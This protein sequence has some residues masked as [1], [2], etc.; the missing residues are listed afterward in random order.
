MLSH[1]ND[2]NDLIGEKKNDVKTNWIQG[3]FFTTK[4]SHDV[5]KDNENLLWSKNED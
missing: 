1:K 3:S 2:S 4:S 5:N